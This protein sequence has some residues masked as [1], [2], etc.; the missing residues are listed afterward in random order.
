MQARLILHSFWDIARMTVR[1][2]PS[3]GQLLPELQQVSR[4]CK[5]ARCGSHLTLRS[6]L[7]A[8]VQ[9]SARAGLLDM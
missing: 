7:D 3:L 5:A 4:P 8:F 9:V 2:E 6:R 1:K